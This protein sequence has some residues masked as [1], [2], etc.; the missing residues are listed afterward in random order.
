[1]GPWGRKELDTT[2]RLKRT[3]TH[4]RLLYTHVIIVYM[5]SFV[6]VVLFNSGFQT[7]E[8]FTPIL[9]WNINMP[10]KKSHQ[11]FK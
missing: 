11:S 10:L 9:I 5:C 4:T 7:K 8:P 6:L 1:M 3:Q 2:E